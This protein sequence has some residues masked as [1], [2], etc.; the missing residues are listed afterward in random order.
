MDGATISKQID[1]KRAAT[2]LQRLITERGFSQK[3]LAKQAKV[4]EAAIS[5]YLKGDRAFRADTGK[6][7][8]DALG[9]SLDF[10]L[11]NSI[12]NATR[13]DLE[14]HILRVKELLTLDDK[15][16]LVRVLFE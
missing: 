13:Q 11:D 7:L 1:N 3:E 12:Q 5:H 8:A 4:T 16:A 9:I 6:R 15:V 2:V 14:E 10:L